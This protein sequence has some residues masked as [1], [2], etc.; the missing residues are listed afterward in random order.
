[1]WYGSYHLLIE[2][3]IKNRDIFCC[4]DLNLMIEN[5]DKLYNI[6]YDTLTR[7]FFIK[8]IEGPYIR[9]IDYCPWCGSKLPSSLRDKWFD[10]LEKEYGL[11]SPD[12]V[13][14]C[15]KVPA[16]FLTDE[17]WKKRGL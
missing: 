2:E 6:E 8:S 7:E 10:I 13:D 1:M 15:N 3:K 17:W 5:E 11:D 12:S 4:K 14:Q 16:E 9:T